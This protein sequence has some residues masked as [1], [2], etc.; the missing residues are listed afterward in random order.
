MNA[1]GSNE[2]N[3]TQHPAHDD[4]PAWSH[5][6]ETIV[7][8]SDRL[9]PNEDDD[10]QRTQR[11]WM[12]PLDTT[13]DPTPTPITTGDFYDQYPDWQPSQPED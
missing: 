2:Q 11:I 7:F 4:R 12:L 1:D 5:D 9:L 6:N 13:A 3:V 8:E 10:T